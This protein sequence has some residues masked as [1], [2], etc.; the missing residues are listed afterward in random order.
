M[1]DK[2][3]KLR[4]HL[5]ASHASVIEGE[6][7]VEVAVDV[8]RRQHAEG[9]FRDGFEHTHEHYAVEEDEVTTLN[10]ASREET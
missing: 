1:I 9:F 4:I 5:A 2:A 8:H 6:P 7:T 10:V 3:K